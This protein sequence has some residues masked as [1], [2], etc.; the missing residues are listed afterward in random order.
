MPLQ[1]NAKAAGFNSGLETV[2]GG[3]QLITDTIRQRAF[4]DDLVKRP[5]GTTDGY[6]PTDKRKGQQ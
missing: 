6:A 5:V 2:S 4:E 1:V 3:R